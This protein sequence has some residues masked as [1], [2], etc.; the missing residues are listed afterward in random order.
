MALKILV[1]IDGTTTDWFRVVQ[2]PE[3]YL[4]QSF[5]NLFIRHTGIPNERC[6][7]LAGPNLWGSKTDE[8]I[9]AGVEFVDQV[10]A[11]NPGHEPE[12]HLVGYS[13]GAYAVMCVARILESRNLRVKFL[14][15]FDAVAKTDVLTDRYTV[16]NSVPRPFGMNLNMVCRNVDHAFHARRSPALGSRTWMGNVALE[17]EAGNVQVESFW[18]THSAMGGMPWGGDHPS[19]T[20]ALQDWKHSLRVGRWMSGHAMRAGTLRS[21]RHPLENN[22]VQPPQWWLDHPEIRP[23]ETERPTEHPRV[24]RPKV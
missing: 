6:L 21:W 17:S 10:I 22:G 9:R 19:G 18:C 15:L 23:T 14:G 13:R 11:K 20:T 4:D 12:I 1:G 5:I 2:F 24:I 16:A 7:Y 3:F 8:L